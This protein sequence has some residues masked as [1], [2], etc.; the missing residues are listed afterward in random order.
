MKPNSSGPGSS[1]DATASMVDDE[2]HTRNPISTSN[3][4]VQFTCPQTDRHANGDAHPSARWNRSKQLWY[5]DVCECGGGVYDLA[6][7]LGL[8]DKKTS[9]ETAPAIGTYD[10]GSFRVLRA[11]GKKFSV[12]HLD[13][14]GSWTSGLGD[15]GTCLY[16]LQDILKLPPGYLVLVVEGEKDVHTAESLGFCATTAPFGKWKDQYSLT[17]L[18]L[19]VVVIADNDLP[20]LKRAL[21]AADSIA[22][23][24]GHVYVIDKMPGVPEKGDLTD[25]VD[26]GGTREEL[27]ALLDHAELKRAP[28]PAH[29]S[30]WTHGA[31]V[32]SH[33]YSLHST[34]RL[35]L[36]LLAQHASITGEARPS[37]RRMAFM[38]G[39]SE[40]TVRKHIRVLKRRGLIR[41]L[42]KGTQGRNN[43]YQLM[44]APRGQDTFAKVTGMRRP[45]TKQTPTVGVTGTSIPVKAEP[46]VR[47]AQITGTGIP[48]NKERTKKEETKEERDS[49]ESEDWSDA[50]RFFPSSGRTVPAGLPSTVTDAYLNEAGEEVYALDI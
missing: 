10:Y 8:F 39:L 2:V 47:T 40:E 33:V 9:Q 42:E 17:L 11:T 50:P 13:S 14:R 7:M 18:G 45:V 27:L 4:E 5:C 34:T 43:H 22:C 49:S 31:D 41:V 21:D 6:R 46:P 35:V 3:G 15:T 28:I 32:V 24:N 26:A 44:F 37:Q 19:R 30:E 1:L 20:G 12:E 23:E 48:P 36:K 16:R 29:H 38:S 25:W